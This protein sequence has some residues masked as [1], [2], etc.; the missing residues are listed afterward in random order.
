M[1]SPHL[2]A[3]KRAGPS[4]GVPVRRRGVPA[5]LVPVLLV[6][7]FL[8]IA[9][10][11]FGDRLWSGPDVEVARV[12]ALSLQDEGTAA[13]GSEEDGGEAAGP[14]P[15]GDAPM[16]FQASGWVEADPWAVEAAALI[17]GIVDEVMVLEGEAVKNGQVLATLVA[18]EHELARDVATRAVDEARAAVS[19]AVAEIDAS[20]K[21]LAAS[22]A[23]LSTEQAR[24]EEA[25]DLFARVE[26]LGEGS[27]PV[28]QVVSARLAVKRIEAEV[29]EEEA[30]VSEVEADV[31]RRHRLLEVVKARLAAAQVR[32]GQAELTL[33][34]TVVSA[35][36]DGVVQ[37]LFVVPG[38]KRAVFMDDPHSAAIAR[39]YQP[40]KL[41]VRV[42]VPLADAA[43]LEVG[44]RTRVVSN[45]LPDRVLPGTVTRI[46]GQADLQRNTLQ[47][48]VRLDETD[49]RL[50]PEMLCRVEFLG[51]GT[52]NRR[53]SPGVARAA[54]PGLRVLVPEEALVDPSSSGR[55]AHLW[56]VEADS[57]RL[58]RR[59]VEPGASAE[60]GHREIRGGVRPGEWVVVRPDGGLEEG[61]RVNPV[62]KES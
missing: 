61:G 59:Q 55:E 60:Q 8:A 33:A 2:S 34:R 35:P 38:H 24:L 32:L 23:R 10:F 49:P 12:V 37:E 46:V 62:F 54:S 7:G 3:L 29:V 43:R 15:V 6:A 9:Y 58:E 39:I 26:A 56:V 17:P 11:L 42:D 22:R 5:L 28:T 20:K 41:Q 25:R 40:E 4:Q 48:K 13:A 18:D 45:L 30:L 57:L 36:I 31:E 44:Q 19:A 27:V 51:A 16:L 50:R 1:S 21:R 52:G 53:A 14:G 47:A